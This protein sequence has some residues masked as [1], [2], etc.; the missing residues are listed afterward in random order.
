MLHPAP[1]Q[2]GS[3]GAQGSA[4]RDAGSWPDPRCCR[5]GPPSAG[6]GWCDRPAHPLRR[7]HDHPSRS[8]G[9]RR[10]SRNARR[11][12]PQKRSSAARCRSQQQ[13][14]SCA[15]AMTFMTT[16][17][18]VDVCASSFVKRF[19]GTARGLLLPPRPVI[20]RT[21]RPPLQD[22]ACLPLQGCA[23]RRGG[24]G[25]MVRL[26]GLLDRPRMPG[27]GRPCRRSRRACASS[28]RRQRQPRRLPCPPALPLLPSL[29]AIP[30]HAPTTGRPSGPSRPP[31]PQLFA[32]RL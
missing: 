28:R 14:S 5:A 12:S 13:S 23:R 32:L 8:A 16:C 6:P 31:G 19:P 1:P 29:I 9:V 20:G 10:R 27:P 24:D 18:T 21:L 11:D 15:L 25:N 2:A 4:P 17:L 7:R 3:V 22:P 30:P 26:L